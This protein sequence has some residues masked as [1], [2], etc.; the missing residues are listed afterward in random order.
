VTL[1]TLVPEEVSGIPT[2]DEQL[3]H[4]QLALTHYRLQHWDRAQA[5]LQQLRPEHSDSWFAGLRRL[6]DER[7]IDHRCIPPPADRDGAYT[8]DSK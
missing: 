3:G 4:W 2:F 7:I 6:L 8:F 5:E 1:F